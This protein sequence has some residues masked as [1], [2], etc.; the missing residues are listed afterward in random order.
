LNPLIYSVLRI[1]LWGALVGAL[2]AAMLGLLRRT[3]PETHRRDWIRL[4]LLIGIGLAIASA[5]ALGPQGL[6]P[7]LLIVAWVSW[8]E[9]VRCV[10]RKYGPVAAPALI[11]LAGTLGVGGGIGGTAASLLFGI[12]AATWGA[13]SLPMLVTRRPPPLHGALGACF[14]MAFISLP[15]GA[16]LLLVRLSYGAF[17]FLIALVTFNDG[18]A[19]GFGRLLGRT[20][21]CPRISP[22]KTWEGA[23]G[24]LAICAG[25][26]YLVRDLVPAWSPWQAALIAAGVSALCLV[27]DLIASS[28]KR[29][30]GI[31]DFGTALPVIGGFLDRFDSLL[32]ATPAFYAIARLTIP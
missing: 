14:G 5:G 23:V 15:L 20:P 13:V 31:K 28:L 27:G 22:G 24:S 21:L 25:L 4:G 17:V 19:A 3:D 7:I 11:I 32:F 12:V 29:E 9:L 1:A 30:A 2:F 6:L 10:E 8:T 26:S 18:F 16:L